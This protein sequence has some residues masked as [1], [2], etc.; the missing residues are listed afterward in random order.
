MVKIGSVNIPTWL[1]VVILLAI[2]SAVVAFFWEDITGG[3]KKK[4]DTPKDQGPSMIDP[5]SIKISAGKY[6]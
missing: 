2:V 5:A 3:S 4:D 1:V 6:S